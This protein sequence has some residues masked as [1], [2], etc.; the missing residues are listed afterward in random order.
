[1]NSAGRTA[2]AW[3]SGF[4]LFAALAFAAVFILSLFCGT[5]SIPLSHF[6]SILASSFGFSSLPPA[7]PWEQIVLWEV[8]L[9]RSLLGAIVGAALA[10][11]GAAMQGMF[12]NPLACPSVTGVSS[13]AALGA[14][15][16]LYLGL[17]SKSPL[18]LPA[19]AF[20][21]ATLSI[22]TVYSVSSCRGQVSLSLLLL[23]G[24]AIGSLNLAFLSFILS[25]SLADYESGRQIVFWTLGGLE[26]SSW[27][28][29][30]LAS[31]LIALGSLWL[32]YYSR[33]LDALLTGELHAASVGVE[34]ARVRG[35][36]IIAA[37]MLTATSVAVCGTIG[38]VGLVV[39]H[40]ARFFAGSRHTALFPACALLGGALVLSADMLART[41]IAPQEIHLG[42]I[43]AAIGA[44]F[45]LYLL[46]S[47]HRG[48][49]YV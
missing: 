8:R 3:R 13:G 11:T 12:R 47:R 17:A 15:L 4:F 23:A 43:T 32:V 14:V 27:L 33:E 42:V 37:A 18:A 19:C 26:Q 44:P 9:P 34:V 41:L 22:W 46:L 31:P 49:A 35:S 45:F 21:G 36:L 16:S 48:N 7:Q 29:L 10:L 30:K 5:V 38:F 1:M 40:I 28:Q 24:V 2:G 20:A 39:P 6:F 25:L